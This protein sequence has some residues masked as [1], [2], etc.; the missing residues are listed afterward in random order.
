VD[1]FRQRLLG[2]SFIFLGLGVIFNLNVVAIPV[3]PFIDNEGAMFL[4]CLFGA[5]FILFFALYDKGEVVK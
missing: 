1:V 4:F 5:V 2:S 3:N